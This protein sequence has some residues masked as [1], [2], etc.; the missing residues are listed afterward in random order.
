MKFELMAETA[1]FG[2]QYCDLACLIMFCVCV[3][4]FF[5][6]PFQISILCV[7]KSLTIQS[8]CLLLYQE[9]YRLNRSFL[10]SNF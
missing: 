7:V 1:A 9:S 2:S 5:F 4:F 8:C 6:F 10:L 3:F